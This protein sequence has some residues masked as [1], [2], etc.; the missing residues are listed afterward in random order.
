MLFWI[1]CLTAGAEREQSFL[2][3]SFPVCFFIEFTIGMILPTKTMATQELTVER[4]PS[5]NALQV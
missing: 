2:S 3:K 1:F 4:K 5:E